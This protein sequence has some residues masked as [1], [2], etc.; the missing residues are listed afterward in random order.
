VA[1]GDFRPRLDTEREPWDTA[2]GISEAQYG[3]RPFQLTPYRNALHVQGTLAVLSV[4]ST[5]PAPRMI[6]DRHLGY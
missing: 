6:R 5:S 1:I 3:H 4:K 2:G